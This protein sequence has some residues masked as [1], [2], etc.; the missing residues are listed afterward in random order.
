MKNKF[1]CEI[2]Q[3]LMPS[4]LDKLTSEVTNDAVLEHIKTC[5]DCKKILTRMENPDPDVPD[6]PN[7]AEIDFLKKT[8]KKTWMSIFLSAAF[9]LGLVLFSVIFIFFIYGSKIHSENLACE[10]SVS[11]Q[12]IT[13]NGTG[14]DSGIGISNISFEESVDGIITIHFRSVLASPLHSGDFEASYTA[15]NPIVQIRLE[16]RILWDKWKTISP[17]VSAVYL[18]KHNYVGDPSANSR[19]FAALDMTEHIGGVINELQTD[20][21]PYGW[22]MKLENELLSADEPSTVQ[23]MESAAYVLI[24]TIDNLE[25]VTFEYTVGKAPKTLTFTS[26][27]ASAYAGE[28]ANIKNCANSPA[29][30]QE[31]MER[32]GLV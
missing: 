15:Q 27:D 17:K 25:Y 13:L 20:Q 23:F 11:D 22:T 28:E 1:P 26:E 16:N 9:A 18:A 19:S 12:T 21:P 32:L 31:L 29:Q 5:P 6:Q 14:L 30:L 3:D 2:I 4:Y 24:A 7:D 10:V 8:R